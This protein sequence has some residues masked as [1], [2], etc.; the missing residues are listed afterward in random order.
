MVTEVEPQTKALIHGITEIIPYDL[1]SIVN[2]QELGQ[3]LSGTLNIDSI[4]LII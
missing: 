3:R 1:L 4:F 2:E